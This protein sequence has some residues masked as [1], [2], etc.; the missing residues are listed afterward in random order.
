MGVNIGIGNGYTQKPYFYIG[1]GLKLHSII[2]KSSAPRTT[3]LFLVF[4]KNDEK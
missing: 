2:N 1:T 4:T 3:F